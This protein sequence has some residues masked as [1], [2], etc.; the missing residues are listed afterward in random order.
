VIVGR[1]TVERHRI[2]PC[3]LVREA[4]SARA[5][6]EEPGLAGQVVDA[7]LAKCAS[8][9]LFSTRL[10]PLS[11]GTRVRALLP[12]PDLSAQILASLGPAGRVGTVRAALDRARAG[13]R[14]PRWA[15]AGEWLTALVPLAVALPLL[16][17]GVFAGH[18]GAPSHVLTPCTAALIHARPP[19]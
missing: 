3:A 8:C 11:R 12:A 4:L 10:V 6:G 19:A 9:G 2:T 5:D 14:R 18:H 17:V 7:H 15:R 13:L 16:A 1:R